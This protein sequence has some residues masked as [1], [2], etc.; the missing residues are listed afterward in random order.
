MISENCLLHKLG[1]LIILEYTNLF[2]GLTTATEKFEFHIKKVYMNYLYKFSFFPG[3]LFDICI[4]YSIN[5]IKSTKIK[6]PYERLMLI[7]KPFLS[8]MPSYL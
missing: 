4:N 8:N 5:L 7:M 6:L 3:I 1:V 2:P